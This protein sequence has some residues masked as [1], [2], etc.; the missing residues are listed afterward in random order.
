MDRP[1]AWSRSDWMKTGCGFASEA[2]KIAP[3]VPRNALDLRRTS[4]TSG[5][6]HHADALPQALT[7][8]DA[9]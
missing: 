6:E 3:T 2:R 5:L 1:G 7:I 4:A 9:G 8:L